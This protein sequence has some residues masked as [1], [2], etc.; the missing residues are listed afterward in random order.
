MQWRQHTNLKST[1]PFQLQCGVWSSTWKPHH[2][3]NTFPEKRLCTCSYLPLPS[4]CLYTVHTCLIEDQ[5]QEHSLYWRNYLRNE[6]KMCYFIRLQQLW[7]I[8][9]GNNEL[10]NSECIFSNTHIGYSQVFGRIWLNLGLS[11]QHY[12]SGQCGRTSFLSDYSRLLPSSYA[13]QPQHSNLR[14][15]YTLQKLGLEVNWHK[16]Q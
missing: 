10:T 12:G 4:H 2:S 5:H 8:V 7:V 14:H 15:L 9:H 6:D 3:H 16:E 13:P 11:S 1:F